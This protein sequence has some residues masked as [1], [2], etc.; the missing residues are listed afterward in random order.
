MRSERSKRASSIWRLIDDQ[1]MALRRG[2][3][4]VSAVLAGLRER[5]ILRDAPG[6]VE[7]VIEAADA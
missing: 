1:P 5:A 2:S 4:D 3:A 6:L 7:L